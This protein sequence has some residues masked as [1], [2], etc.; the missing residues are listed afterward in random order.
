MGQRTQPPP[1]TESLPV[2]EAQAH[3]DLGMAF[4]QLGLLADALT[5]LEAALR[6]NPLHRSAQYALTKSE[7]LRKE[8]RLPVRKLP[9]AKA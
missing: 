4:A 2:G 5:H 6:I 8:L 1:E 9:K 3:Y 7:E